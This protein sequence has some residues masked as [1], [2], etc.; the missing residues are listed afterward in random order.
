M[1]ERMSV[2]PWCTARPSP[3]RTDANDAPAG[4]GAGPTLDDDRAE[5]AEGAVAAGGARTTDSDMGKRLLPFPV[6]RGRGAVAREMVDAASSPMS[7]PVP[8]ERVVVAMGGG[9]A[10]GV[11]AARRVAA[12]HDVVG[13]TLHLWDYP[14]EGAG[15]HGRC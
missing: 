14:E 15:S 4:A 6:D 3:E 12:G 8:R 5:A 13:V 11:G 10:W 2:S 1:A 7:T 9:A